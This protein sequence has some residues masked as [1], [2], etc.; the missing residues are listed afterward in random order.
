MPFMVLA[1]DHPSPE[2]PQRRQACRADHLKLGEKLYNEGKWLCAAA[3]LNDRGEAI[4]SII[5]C[6]FPDLETLK[7]EWLNQEP[8]LLNQVWEKIQIH[9]I[10][11]A[12]FMKF[13]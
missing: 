2:G 3:I 1:F 6:D 9:P 12:P 4:G 7:S 11:P 5:I 13:E 10:R 8:Y